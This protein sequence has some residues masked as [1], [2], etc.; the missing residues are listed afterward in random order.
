MGIGSLLHKAISFNSRLP[1][2][3]PAPFGKLRTESRTPVSPELRRGRGVDSRF[4][5]NDGGGSGG[6]M[7]TE[8]G[9]TAA[10]EALSQRERVG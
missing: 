9:T 1:T 6:A 8:D 2:V 3:I 10:P 5:G 4:R 7:R